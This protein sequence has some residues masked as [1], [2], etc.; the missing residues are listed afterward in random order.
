MS[1]SRKRGSRGAEAEGASLVTVTIFG[2]SYSLRAEED[3]S[4]VEELARHVDAKMRTLSVETGV[5]E[6][7]RVAVLAALNLADE[8]EKLRERHRSSEEALE[9]TARE[10]T[11]A[12]DRALR[13]P[14]DTSPA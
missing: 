12:L 14:R 3:G 10:L 2:H 7:G 1:D 8:L 9:T 13:E 11:A 5:T 6:A 4:Y